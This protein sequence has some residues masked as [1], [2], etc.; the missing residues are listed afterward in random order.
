ME[1][2]EFAAHAREDVPWLLAEVQRLRAALPAMFDA[3]FAES[4]EG[5]NGEYPVEFNAD[6]QQRYETA[7]AAAVVAVD[8]PPRE[9][10]AIPDTSGITDM[11]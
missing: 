4:G 3:G 7:R 1:D 8:T 9:A 10:A 2:C 5:W 6:Q 11:P